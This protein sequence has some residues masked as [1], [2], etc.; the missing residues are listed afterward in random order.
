MIPRWLVGAVCLLA[1]LATCALL[2]VGRISCRTTAPNG[3]TA[4]DLDPRVEA[5]TVSLLGV[6]WDFS[7]RSL[8]GWKHKDNAEISIADDGDACVLRLRSSFK[9]YTFTW[10]ARRFEPRTAE[11]V[12]HITFRVRGDSSAHQLRVHLTAPAQGGKTLHYINSR[13][14][15]TLDFSGWRQVRADLDQF[16]TPDNGLRERDLAR[17]T[18]VEFTVTAANQRGGVDI[19]LDDIAFTGRTAEEIAEAERSDEERKR[20][21]QGGL[22]ALEKTEQ[23][24]A[25]LG[26]ELERA[27]EHGKFVDEARVYWTGLEWC[28]KDVRRLLRADEIEIVRQAE[29][30]LAAIG[31]RLDEPRQVLDRVCE[32]PQEGDPFQAASNP[33]FN[34][35]VEHIR[36]AAKAE[37]WWAKGRQGF[38]SIPDAWSFRHMGDEAYAM[39]WAITRPQSSLRRH[40]MLLTNALNVLETIAHQHTE[41]DFN[42][43]RTAAHGR[44]ANINRFCL[45]P[46]LDAWWELTAAYPDLLPQPQRADIERGLRRLVEYQVTDHGLARLAAHP[47]LRQPA[48]PNMDAHYLLIME[49]AHRL[50]KDP[51]YARERDGFLRILQSAVY[52]MG[53]FPYIHTQNE[54][55]VY[56]HLD[57]V[58][59]ARFWKLTGDP[60]ALELLRKTVPYYPRNVEPAGMSEYYTDPSWKHYWS[61]NETAGPAVIA[62]LFDDPFNQRAA[63]SCAKIWRYGRGHVAAIAAEVWKPV[64][65]K[66]LPDGYVIFDANIQGPRGRFGPWSFAANGRNYGVGS[67]GKDTFVGCMLTEALASP[68]PLDSA[69]QV[70]TAEVRLNQTGNHWNGGCCFSA[71]EKLSTALGPDFGSLAVCYTVSAP[72]WQ[73]KRDDPLPWEGVQTWYLS[74]S[75]LVGLVSLEATAD[76]RHA[77]VHGRIRLGV[78]RTLDEIG[79]SSW[80]YGRMHVAIHAH[81]YATIT[82]LPSET[83]FQD[84]PKS[85]R[86]TEITLL[87]PLSVEAGPGRASE[88]MGTGTSRWPDSRG[89]T[90]GAADP[91]PILSQA[92]GDV[93]FRKGTKYWFLVEIRAEGSPPADAVERMEASGAVGFRFHEPGRRVWVLHNRTDR[94][95]ERK[96]AR[97][98]APTRS[99]DGVHEQRRQGP[100]GGGDRFQDAVRRASARGGD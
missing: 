84:D 65:S 35:V 53:A 88:Q 62:G 27:A 76:N 17:V 95:I 29:P 77:G 34:S 82:S 97:Q 13:Q 20:R 40:P 2:L 55:P 46:A 99:P 4:G 19:R 64:A 59:L 60:A 51:R 91:V 54:C 86:S 48:Y 96:H 9:P 3:V 93:L 21:I 39:V 12:A 56:H 44:D 42:V 30:M 58:Y 100:G 7:D 47:E 87:D 16:Q 25:S 98:H 78:K 43:D 90:H 6:R 24:L 61:G 71:R 10:A 22:A 14:A 66:P 28:A 18:S 50:W 8:A 79:P 74:K 32:R 81:N 37:R 63:E 31:R 73:S 92:R 85:Y 67:Q 15:V 89:S 72:Q 36:P 80:K 45:A 23:R 33:F 68:L 94:P 49:L 70:V 5:A 1:V 38:R 83:T 75:R 69:L 26:G 57:V 52:P 11:G 41:G